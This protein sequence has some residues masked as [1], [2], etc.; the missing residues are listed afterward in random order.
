[1]DGIETSHIHNHNPKK[2]QLPCETLSL[3]AKVDAISRLD[4]TFARPKTDQVSR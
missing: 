2:L 4:K 1:M 3:I